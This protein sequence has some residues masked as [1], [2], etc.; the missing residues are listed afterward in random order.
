M[1]RRQVRIIGVAVCFGAFIFAGTSIAKSPVDADDDFE[2]ASDPLPPGVKERVFIHLPRTHKPNHLG[3]CTVT[4]NDRVPD[5]GL[6]GWQLPPGPI[7][8]RLNASTIPPSVSDAAVDILQAAFDTWQPGKFVYGGTTSGNR[9]RL[10]F[11]NAVLWGKVSA[12]AIAITYVR[13]YTATGDVADVDTIFN[14]RYP[15]AAFPARG[16]EC[17]SSPDAYD[18]QNIATH[19]FG[20]WLGLEDLYSAQERDLTMYGYGAGGELKKRTLGD[21]DILGANAVAP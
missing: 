5:Y 4:Q 11:V 7:T 3:E 14:S 20:H 18:V 6:A 2:E 9:S 8:W 17:Q 16:G 21:G 1:T 15:W 13:Y 19:E 12:G 10:D